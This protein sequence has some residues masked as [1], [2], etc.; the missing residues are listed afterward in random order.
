MTASRFPPELRR[1]LLRYLA[2]TSADRARLIG[3]LSERNAGRACWP[4][5]RP[6]TTSEPGS[7]SSC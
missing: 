3:E 1:D 4:T 5:S 7:R 2:A 6:T